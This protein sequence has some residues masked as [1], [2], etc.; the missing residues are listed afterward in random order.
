MAK[1]SFKSAGIVVT[2][3][4]SE[5]EAL[6]VFWALNHSTPKKFDGDDPVYDALEKALVQAAVSHGA[7]SDH[8]YI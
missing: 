5:D 1:A 2:L 8:I 4:L 3:E 6:Y 7:K